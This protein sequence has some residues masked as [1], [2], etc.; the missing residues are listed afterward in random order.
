MWLLCDEFLFVYFLSR[1]LYNLASP[2]P[3]PG[4]LTPHILV[5]FQVKTQHS[6]SLLTTIIAYL[7]QTFTSCF[8]SCPERLL[9]RPHYW[10]DQKRNVPRSGK[11]T[12]NGGRFQ[13]ES[14]ATSSRKV[15]RELQEMLVRF[16]YPIL[17]FWRTISSK[18]TERSSKLTRV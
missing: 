14:M 18:M 13:K 1:C 8:P 3:T 5:S 11:D 16:S 2:P 12:P 10:F 17:E 4:F 15:Y 6:F 9:F 7:I